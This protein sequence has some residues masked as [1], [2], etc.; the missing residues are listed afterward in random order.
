[1]TP[2]P[3][4]NTTE[5]PQQCESFIAPSSLRLQCRPTPGASI[6]H[7]SAENI[8]LFH[9]VT[10]SKQDFPNKVHHFTSARNGTDDPWQVFQLLRTCAATCPDLCFS[11]RE[12][13]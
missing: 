6:P 11:L 12:R 9:Y 13:P 5:L 2:V 10:Q 7:T 4:R 8:A 3:W 1:M